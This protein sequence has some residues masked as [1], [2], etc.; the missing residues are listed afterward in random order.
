MG[1]GEDGELT[2]VVVWG[3]SIKC[4]KRGKHGKKGWETKIFRKEMHFG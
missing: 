3:N 2:G 1:T 4:L